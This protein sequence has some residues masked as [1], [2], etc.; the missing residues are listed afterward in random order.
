MR[1]NII[2]TGSPTGTWFHDKAGGALYV[3]IKDDGKTVLDKI[4]LSDAAWHDIEISNMTETDIGTLKRKIETEIQS[5]VTST[6]DAFVRVTLSGRC[7]LAESLTDEVINEMADELSGTLDIAV[8]MQKQNLQ[9]IIPKTLLDATSPFVESVK[10]IDLLKS[11]DEKFEQLVEVMQKKHELF[12]ST[13]PEEKRKK[14]GAD[15]K[16][17]LLGRHMQSHGKG[18]GL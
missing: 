18:G 11:D 4:T 15:F 12:Y 7:V 17:G 10:I 5:E 2:F 8:F 6:K 3:E 1:E 16:K 9:P 14:Y 13:I